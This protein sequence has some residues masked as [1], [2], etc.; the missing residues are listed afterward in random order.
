VWEVTT[1]RGGEDCVAELRMV[2]SYFVDVADVASLALSPCRPGR[3]G[4]ES[5][6]AAVAGSGL[7]LLE[8]ELVDCHRAAS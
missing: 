6:L 7:Q 8:L 1:K 5:Y 3:E 4:S 2:G